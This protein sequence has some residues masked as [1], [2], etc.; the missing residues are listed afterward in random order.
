MGMFGLGQPVPRTEDPRLLTG[1]GQYVSDVSFSDQAYA[2]TVRSPVSHAK[3]TSINIESAS[4]KPG[5]L[6][7]YLAEDIENAGL[8]VTKPHFPPRTRPGDGSHE[9]WLSHPG[10]VSNYVKMIGDPIAF[11]VADSIAEA[12]DA[13]ENI[14]FEFD[15]LPTITNTSLATDPSSPQ[16]HDDFPNNISNIFSIGNKDAVDK[17]FENAAHITRKT[18]II[19]RI[20]TNPMETRGCVGVYDYREDRYTLYCDT[21]GPH[22]SRQ[23]L[24]Q[25]IF[26]IPENKIRIIARDIGGAFGLKD[27]HFPENRLCLLAAKELKRPVKWVCERSESFVADDHARDVVS[28]AALALD[29]DGNFM[30]IRIKNTNNLGAYLTASSGMVPTFL[31]LGTLA[32]VYK[33]SAI[34]VEVTSVYTNTQST[35]PYR[36]AGR[37]EAA[38]ILES[39]IDLAAF[40][41]K[42]DRIELRR[43]NIIPSSAMPFQTGLIFKYDSGH[44]EKNMD[45]ATK[46]GDIENFNSRRIKAEE[47]GKL[48]GF[49]VIHMIESAGGARPEHAEICFDT[50]GDITVCVGTKSQGQG[51]ETM[52]KIMVSSMLGIDSNS[53]NVVDGDTDKVSF[54]IGTIGSRSALTGGGAIKLA[55][56]KIIKKGSKIAA[57]MMEASEAD[58]EFNSGIFTVSGTDKSLSIR[59][60]AKAAFNPLNIPEDVE[61]GL[62]EQSTYTPKGASFPN[63]CHVCEVEIDRE[64]G[65]ISIERY[66]AVDDVGT[67]VNPLTLAG[68]IHGG[69]VQ[70][71]GQALMENICYDQENG[72]MLSGSFL[73]YAMPRADDFCGFQVETHSVPAQSNILGIKGAGEAGTTGALPAVMNAVNHALRDHGVRELEMPLTPEKVWKALNT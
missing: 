57:Q 25:E 72:Q 32:G 23:Q 13:A 33:T 4:S 62:Y 37:P 9:Y 35:T 30:A 60:I 34:H 52:Y 28:D 16:L 18:F 71:A 39:L 47:N 63:G 65:K 40:E 2:I 27:T 26:H 42:I 29:K 12:K 17:A 61:A 14:S 53:I 44:F 66:L 22:A 7:I 1:R 21:Q 67:V 38:Y 68:Q 20:S 55:A 24:A 69:I 8:G 48:R 5:V 54:G 11:V 31:N 43:R 49:S 64:T 19:N 70:G 58:I 50:S 41:M 10:L 56:D 73:D 45:T 36:G 6:K 51:H 59:D 15:E 46:I 3:I